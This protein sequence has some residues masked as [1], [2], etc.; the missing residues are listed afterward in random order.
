MIIIAVVVVI[1]IP[2][3]STSNLSPLPG[4]ALPDGEAD[5][6]SWDEVSIGRRGTG[7]DDKGDAN[8]ESPTN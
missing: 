7:G 1:I 4:E 8:G 6:D 5:G 3:H 2:S